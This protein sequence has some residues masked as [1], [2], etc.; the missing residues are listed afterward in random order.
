MRLSI[1]LA[2]TLMVVV[3]SVA[4]AKPKA[5]PLSVKVG[6]K[7]NTDGTDGSSKVVPPTG[8]GREGDLV[9]VAVA[10]GQFTTLVKVVTD[11]GLV[12]TIKG[13]EA[14]TI[15]APNDAAFAE[16]DLSSLT[17]EQKKA[18][19]LR[20][21][22]VGKVMAADVVTGKVKTFGGEEIDLFVDRWVQIKYMGGSSNV[23]K[24]DVQACNGVIHVIDSV[25]LPKPGKVVTPTGEGCEGD[26]VDVAVAA[27]Q[28]K[29]LVKAVTD[30][31]L[32]DTI[33][34]AEAL[35]IFAPN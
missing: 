1:V 18:V 32:V 15:F 23:I 28:F 4:E 13:A 9:D 25:I 17:Q 35:T 7:V 33:K 26:L 10:A 29:N 21:V 27:R 11:L 30:L 16:E 3:A 5:K 31:G 34:G 2:L 8:E 20:H 22:V 6:L 12:D 24:A 14:L 19:V